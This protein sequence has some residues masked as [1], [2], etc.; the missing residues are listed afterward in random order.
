MEVINVGVGEIGVSN[1]PET[2]VK[3]Y[4]LGSCIALIFIAPKLNAVGMAH[5]ALPDSNYSNGKAKSL[6]GYFADLAIPELIEKF[7]SFGVKKN[8]EVIVKMTGGAKI[9]DP[10]GRFNI[11]KRNVL[12]TKK[13]LWKYKLGAI[14][15][16][17]GKNF[18]RTV[19][20]DTDSGEIKITS[21]GRG[22]WNI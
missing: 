17:I 11:G 9:M 13:I 20:V 16:D 21:P 22:M 5:I 14:A 6:P 12:A 3:T 19:S 1:N 8:S 10:E 7:K 4:A 18:S 15:E 2:M